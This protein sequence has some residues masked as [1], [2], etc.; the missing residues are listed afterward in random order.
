MIPLNA[1][2]EEG[3]YDYTVKDTEGNDVSLKE[4]GDLSWDEIREKS[5]DYAWRNTVKDRP[6]SMKD[7][8][9]E[10]GDSSE[11]IEFI[12]NMNKIKELINSL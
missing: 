11:Y 7:L 12:D 6:I 2:E 10:K 5:H 3:R 1:K 4:Y 9:L 8:L